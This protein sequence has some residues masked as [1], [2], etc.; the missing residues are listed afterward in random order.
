[1]GNAEIVFFGTNVI[2]A[3]K[4]INRAVQYRCRKHNSYS[5]VV[6]LFMREI[7]IFTSSC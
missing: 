5:A 7:D 4:S 6:M 2:D 1:M 3:V